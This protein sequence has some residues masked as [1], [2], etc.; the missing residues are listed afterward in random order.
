MNNALEIITYHDGSKFFRKDIDVALY[1]VSLATIFPIH[2]IRIIND[3]I[4]EDEDD[5]VIYDLSKTDYAVATYKLLKNK[6]LNY[7]VIY[8]D[9]LIS[10]HVFG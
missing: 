10:L 4:G 6:T 8:S 9:G 2:S 7:F 1:L 5:V 3:S